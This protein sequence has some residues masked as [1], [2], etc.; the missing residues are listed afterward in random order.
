MLRWVFRVNIIN[1]MCEIFKHTHLKWKKDI[2][3]KKLK[4]MNNSSVFTIIFKEYTW[5]F[6]TNNIENN[7]H[8]LFLNGK[9]YFT[10]IKTYAAIVL[11]AN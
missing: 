6:T 11:F 1:E 10:I 5:Y 4:L 3:T 9:Y 8:R 2:E 7:F